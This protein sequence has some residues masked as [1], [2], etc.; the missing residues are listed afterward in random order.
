MATSVLIIVIIILVGNQAVLFLPFGKME[1]AAAEPENKAAAEMPTPIELGV[2]CLV[3]LALTLT[4]IL[5]AAVRECDDKTAKTA[6]SVALALNVTA[7]G[8][9]LSMV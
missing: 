4:V 1:K 7:A 6:N 3:G 9:L 5:L 2:S 8:F